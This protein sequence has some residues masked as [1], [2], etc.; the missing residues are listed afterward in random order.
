MD[1]KLGAWLAKVYSTV[2]RSGGSRQ[3]QPIHRTTHTDSPCQT[4]LSLGGENCLWR[5]SDLYDHPKANP[6]SPSTGSKR[7]VRPRVAVHKPSSPQAGGKNPTRPKLKVPRPSAKAKSNAAPAT[8]TAKTSMIKNMLFQQSE[9][10]VT[11]C[12]VL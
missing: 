9:K 6:V 8:A 4:S 3:T 2:Q 12:L 10:E 5:H 1:K 11:I 7:A